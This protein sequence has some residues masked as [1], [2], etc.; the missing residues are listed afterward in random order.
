MHNIRE[1]GRDVVLPLWA[2]SLQQTLLVLP[3]TAPIWIRGL[4]TFLVSKRFK[5]Y[6]ALGWCY[7]VCFTVFFLLHGKI[8][9]LSPVYPMLLAAGAVTIEAKIEG[10]KSEASE[11]D[12]LPS[13]PRRLTC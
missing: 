13:G 12:A 1:D 6:R 10:R 5:P 7:L 11:N 4:I 3:L 2:Y 9:Y 8:Y